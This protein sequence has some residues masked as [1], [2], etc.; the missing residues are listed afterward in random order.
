MSKVQVPNEC[1]KKQYGSFKS[2]A[3]FGVHVGGFERRD[4]HP[5]TCGSS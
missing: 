4:T 1:K 5:H 2:E 3:E